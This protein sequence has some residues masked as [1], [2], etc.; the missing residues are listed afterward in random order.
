MAIPD[1]CDA[2]VRTEDERPTR[3]PASSSALP[4]SDEGRP[5]LIPDDEPRPKST[6]AAPS[7]SVRAGLLLGSVA[8]PL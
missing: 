1:D 4:G 6:A 3:S 7:A 5:V 2:S 8:V